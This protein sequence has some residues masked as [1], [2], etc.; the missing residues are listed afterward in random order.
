LKKSKKTTI[1]P[2]K[3]SINLPGKIKQIF[4][5]NEMDRNRN[6]MSY[7]VKAETLMHYEDAIP[8]N[9]LKA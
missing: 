1:L 2:K 8:N 7:E 6:D 5:V 3:S 9:A 4:R